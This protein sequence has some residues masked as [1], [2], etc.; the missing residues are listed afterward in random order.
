MVSYPAPKHDLKFCVREVQ[1]HT[2]ADGENSS[3]KM[4]VP[5]LPVVSIL[6]VV[7]LKLRT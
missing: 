1:C 7:F 4:G 2:R 6:T 5:P 3:V